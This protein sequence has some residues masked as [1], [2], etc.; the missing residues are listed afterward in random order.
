MDDIS[1]VDLRSEI[2]D[3]VRDCIDEYSVGMEYCPHKGLWQE[4][5]SQGNDYNE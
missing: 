4:Q 3:Y 2:Q 5:T 1:V